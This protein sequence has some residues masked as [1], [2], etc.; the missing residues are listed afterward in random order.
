MHGDEIRSGHA[1]AIEAR[2]RADR[3]GTKA[4][5]ELVAGLLQMRLDRQIELPRVNDDFLPAR[6]AYGIGSVR[7]QRERELRLVFPRVARGE[8]RLQVAA[9]VGGVRRRK[10]EHRQAD[11]GADAALPIGARGGIGKKILVGAARDAA[12]QHFAGGDERAIVHE[13]GR[14]EAGFARPDMLFEPD[15]ECDVV[16]DAAQERHCGVGMRVNEAR[17]QNVGG[18]R[19][20]L[21]GRVFALRRRGRRDGDDASA[22]HDQRVLRENAFGLDRYDPAGVDT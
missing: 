16:G 2:E 18:Q 1:E 10:V 14:H 17:E 7:R 11:E 8:A 21:A 22:V 5:L 13:V 20:T 15:F 19:D 6:V 4:L 9:G 3:M 12:Q